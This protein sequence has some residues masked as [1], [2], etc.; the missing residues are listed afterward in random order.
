MGVVFPTHPRT[1]KMLELCGLYDDL[2]RDSTEENDIPT[3]FKQ[4]ET[5]GKIVHWYPNLR[6][7]NTNMLFER[8]HSIFGR[9]ITA[10]TIRRRLISMWSRS[11]L[12][13]LMPNFLFTLRSTHR[14]RRF[15]RN[16]VD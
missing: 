15:R 4:D 6:R 16:K 13:S 7:K 5:L 2:I 12:A 10:G 14:S 11:Q 8:R 9:G 1:E 3:R